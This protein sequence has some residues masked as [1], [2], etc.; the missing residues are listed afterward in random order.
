MK[1][2][3]GAGTWIINGV[4][5]DVKDN[6]FGAQQLSHLELQEVKLT[7]ISK[8]LQISRKL[9]RYIDENDEVDY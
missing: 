7:T 3:K 2:V 9:Q 6:I 4:L 5:C 1:Y 8:L